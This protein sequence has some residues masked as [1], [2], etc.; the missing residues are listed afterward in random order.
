MKIDVLNR[1][2][3][4]VGEI[5]LNDAIF[6]VPVNVPVMHQAVRVYLNSLRAPIRIQ[7]ISSPTVQTL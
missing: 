4:S 2:G 6:A 7:A 3:T 5:E 1:E